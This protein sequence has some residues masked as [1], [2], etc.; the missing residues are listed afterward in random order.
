MNLRVTAAAL[1]LAGAGIAAYLTWTHA[2][3]TAPV[4]SSG[5]CETVQRS[6]YSELAGLPVATL[7]L[8]AYVTILG[9]VLLDTPVLRLIAAALAAVGLAFSLYLLALQLFVIDAICTW[10]I[11]NDAV[12]LALAA[13]TALRARQLQPS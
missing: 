10:C 8:V 6:R 13:V 12:A 9:L 2:T 7:G 3:G 11:G 5:G 4:C 1:A